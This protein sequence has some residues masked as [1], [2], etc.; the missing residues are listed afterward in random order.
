[1]ADKKNNPAQV[2]DTGHVWDGI[3]ELN[4]PCP[5]WWLNSLW[6]SGPMTGTVL[7]NLR[8]FPG[9]WGTAILMSVI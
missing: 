4:N 8:N 6:L 9:L 1:M 2:E 7:S 3:R 5:R